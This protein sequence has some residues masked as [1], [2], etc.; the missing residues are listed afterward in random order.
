V[1]E[2]GGGEDRQREREW[3][4]RRWEIDSNMRFNINLPVAEITADPEPG[5]TQDGKL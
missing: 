3:G 1:G 2:R 5:I 4:G